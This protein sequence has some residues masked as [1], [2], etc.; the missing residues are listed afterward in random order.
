MKTIQECE[1]N[2]ENIS[3]RDFYFLCEELHKEGKTGRIR[4]PKRLRDLHRKLTNNYKSDEEIITGQLIDI[5][6]NKHLQYSERL[7][8]EIN[9]PSHRKKK[10]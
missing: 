2:L 6:N 4:F 9:T 10:E 1:E 3:V 8:L 5:I 7:I